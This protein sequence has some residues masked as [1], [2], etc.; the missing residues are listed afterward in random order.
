MSRRKEEHPLNMDGMLDPHSLLQVKETEPKTYVDR[1]QTDPSDD[2]SSEPRKPPIKDAY[3]GRIYPHEVW[4]VIDIWRIQI[5]DLGFPVKIWMHDLKVYVSLPKSALCLHGDVQNLIGV[6]LRLHK[7]YPNRVV[8]WVACEFRFY[9]KKD[10]GEWLGEH[11]DDEDSV[12]MPY[13]E[14]VRQSIEL[15]SD[16]LGDD[17]FSGE[18]RFEFIDDFDVGNAIYEKIDELLENPEIEK[19]VSEKG[20]LNLTEGLLKFIHYKCGAVT[21]STISALA[22]L[23]DLWLD[24]D[25]QGIK[26]VLGYA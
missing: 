16:W 13:W 7:T 24:G 21:I 1:D 19:T 3:P 10:S 2:G 20:L 22:I 6:R 18:R 23:L 26:Y 9:E 12:P 4:E 15:Y 25:K 5:D 14:K 8:Y 17:V 11:Q